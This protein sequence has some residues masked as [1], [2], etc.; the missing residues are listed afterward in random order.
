M[1][2]LIHVNEFAIV[3]TSLFLVGCWYVVTSLRTTNEAHWRELLMVTGGM[4]VLVS[5]LAWQ[6]ALARDVS[7]VAHMGITAATIVGLFLL[8]HQ[9]FRA[10]SIVQLL[11]L[12]SLC[13][14]AHGLLRWWPW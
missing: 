7:W 5:A 2:I 3:G 10:R 14:I 1:S 9:R 6:Q 13:A 4:L 12:V 11:G 8:L